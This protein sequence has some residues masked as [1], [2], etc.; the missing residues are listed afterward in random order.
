MVVGREVGG[1]QRRHLSRCVSQ[2]AAE[3]ENCQLAQRVEAVADVGTAPTGGVEGVFVRQAAPNQSLQGCPL[4][5]W[6]RSEDRFHARL[7]SKLD[8]IS[9][10]R[11]GK[12]IKELTKQLLPAMVGRRNL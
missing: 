5:R 3:K 9:S 8:A 4:L 1:N 12:P 7:I 11:A 6:C 2:V 10:N